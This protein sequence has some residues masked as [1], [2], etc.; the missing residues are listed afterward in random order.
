LNQSYFADLYTAR[1][2]TRLGTVY[3]K[4]IYR[5]YTDA[6]FTIPVAHDPAL[7]FLGPVIKAEGK[8][9]RDKRLASD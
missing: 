9:K 4:V 8:R 5:Q 3:R 1:N 6:T 7:G 2:A